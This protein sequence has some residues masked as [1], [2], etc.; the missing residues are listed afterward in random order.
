[1]IGFPKARDIA[2]FSDE[3]DGREYIKAWDGFE[4]GHIGI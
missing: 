4:Q 3:S 2:D 1:L